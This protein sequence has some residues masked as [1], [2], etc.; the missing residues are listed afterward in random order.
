MLSWRQRE[1]LLTRRLPQA[2]VD[3]GYLAPTE[4]TVT[5]NVWRINWRDSKTGI[6]VPTA[7]VDYES[8]E[9]ADAALTTLIRHFN[10]Y[11]A[12]IDRY[13]TE[14]PEK[15]LMPSRAKEI[16]RQ[17]LVKLNLPPYKLTAKTVDFTDLARARM[18]FVRIHGWKPDPIYGELDRIA[19]HNDFRIEA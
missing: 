9:A 15:P 7:Q 2:F 4:D 14:V 5:T 8:W 6:A 17:A 16:I 12:T 1:D 10:T 11:T 18:V 3:S 19:R 13:V